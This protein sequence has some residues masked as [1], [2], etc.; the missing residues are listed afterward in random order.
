MTLLNVTDDGID[1]LGKL[2]GRM[3]AR[4][5]DKRR[6][7]LDAAMNDVFALAHPRNDVPLNAIIAAN[8]TAPAVA[9]YRA[10]L[11]SYYECEIDAGLR[12]GEEPAWRKR[13]LLEQDA[14][15]RIKR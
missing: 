10:A 14:K 7:V 4:E 2:T 5:W 1:Q 6:A 13:S 3:A 9:A 12:Y 11:A 8:E 15:R